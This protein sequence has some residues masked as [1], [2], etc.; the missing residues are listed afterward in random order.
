[1]NRTR[2]NRVPP[3]KAALWLFAVLAMATAVTLPAAQARSAVSTA[4]PRIVLGAP[5]YAGQFGRGW[6]K[7]KPRT[8]FNGGAPS[9]LVV[10]IRWTGWGEA[11]ARGRGRIAIYKPG[12]GYFPKRVRIQLR[13]SGR[14]TCPGTAGQLAYTELEAR[15]PSRPGGGL[16]DW[17]SWS[18]TDDICS[19]S[20]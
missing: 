7:A 2:R 6:G 16:G 17:F 3:R 19:W 10:G 9:G 1:M 18:G 11:V 20:Y 4:K 14:G 12:G 8:I 15:V 13:A 5:D